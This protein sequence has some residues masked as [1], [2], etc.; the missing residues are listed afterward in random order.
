MPKFILLEDRLRCRRLP[1]GNELNIWLGHMAAGY[2]LFQRSSNR[3]SVSNQEGQGS[4]SNQEGYGSESRGLC[5]A[6]Q[7]PLPKIQL[8]SNFLYPYGHKATGNLYL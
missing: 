7:Y 2:S 5:F 1:E 6:F 8:A 3:I 4:D